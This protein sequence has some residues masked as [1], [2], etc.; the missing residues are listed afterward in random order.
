MKAGQKLVA[1]DGY[2]VCLYPLPS[3]DIIQASPS[4]FSH[5]CGFPID[6]NTIPPSSYATMYAPCDCEFYYRDGIGNSCAFIS[7][8]KVHTPSGLTYVCFQFTHGKLLGKGATQGKGAKYK[9][10]E[11]IYTTG[12]DNANGVDH[13]HIDQCKANSANDKVTMRFMGV[14]CTSGNACWVLAKSCK[15]NEIFYVNDTAMTGKL[16]G[17][18]WIKW[19]KGGN[20]TIV[21][22]G[23]GGGSSGTVNNPSLK[24]VIPVISGSEYTRS[25]YL[26][27]SEMKNNFRCFYGEMHARGWSLNAISGMLG[28]IQS[29][30]QCNPNCWQGMYIYSQPTD[31]EGY[32]LVQWTP[33]TKIK[34]WMQ[35]K[36]AWGKFEKYG[37]IQCERIEWEV[38]NNA[39]WMATAS[40]PMSFQE[41]KK[42][43]ASP[44]YLAMVFLA[45]Y[46]RP[47]NPY[48]PIRG[49]Q[50]Q[51]I[52]NYLKGFKPELPN[53]A[54]I[55]GDFNGD[56]E[57]T[58]T[59]EQSKKWKWIYYMKGK[60]KV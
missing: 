29:E 25:R 13:C 58:G 16:G 32:G 19:T 1:N 46:E 56:D 20:N 21:G 53:G 42:S 28:N 45:N 12:L 27:E 15:P 35:Q 4:P 6:V 50:A 17:Y 59:E 49:T 3:M 33:Y 31:T 55:D 7:T 36:G 22:G 43:T 30:S 54:I 2:Q 23:S 47:L 51:S 41:F 40:Y 26:T 8:N 18:N 11:A 39:Q 48:Q 9:Q 24:W 5:C 37:T 52:Y 60:N 38:K 34:E 10:G 44:S 14:Y 57:W